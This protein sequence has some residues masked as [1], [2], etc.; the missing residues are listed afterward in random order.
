[1]FRKIAAVLVLGSFLGSASGCSAVSQQEQN[2]LVGA[3]AGAIPVMVIG[4]AVGGAKGG[5]IGAAAGAMAGAAIGASQPTDPPYAGT[6]V[7]RE[8][9]PPEKKF[10]LAYIYVPPKADAIPRAE[11]EQALRARGWEVYAGVERPSESTFFTA[12]RTQAGRVRAEVIQPDG[13]HRESAG[14]TVSEALDLA[15]AKF[16]R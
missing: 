7:I 10:L 2:T 6:L 13:D 12:W 14:G 3:V 8:V 5:A 1:M 16:Q 4:A 11:L 9:T 15:L